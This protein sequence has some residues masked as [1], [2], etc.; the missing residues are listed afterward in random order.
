[1]VAARLSLPSNE[2][3]VSFGSGVVYTVVIDDVGL[4]RL[5]KRRWGG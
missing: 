3:I 2:R 1:V 5:Q 4:E